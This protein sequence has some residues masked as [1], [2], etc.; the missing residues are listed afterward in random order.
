[1]YF[2]YQNEHGGRMSGHPGVQFKNPKKIQHHQFNNHRANLI[3]P[4]II[5]AREPN[6]NWVVPHHI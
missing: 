4:C 1:M 2:N 5:K 6:R 3:K